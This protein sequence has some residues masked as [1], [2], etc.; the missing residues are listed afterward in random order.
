MQEIFAFHKTYIKNLVILT[1]TF[2]SSAIPGIQTVS[3]H[4]H[5]SGKHRVK[6]EYPPEEL[7]FEDKQ[8]DLICI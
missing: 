7:A 6:Y 2:N 5:T 1:L 3:C 4:Q 8:P